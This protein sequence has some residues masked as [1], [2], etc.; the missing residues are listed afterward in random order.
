MRQA[1]SIDRDN[2]PVASFQPYRRGLA[3]AFAMAGAISFWVPDVII[4]AEA[5]PSLDAKHGWAIT[6]LAPAIFLFAYIVARRF[7]LK[8]RYDRVGLMM[9]LGVWLSGGLFMTIASIL[10]KSEFIGGTGLW[11]LVP[12]VISVIPIATY[13]LAAY[14]GSLFAL[15]AITM[16][17]LL[18][19]GFR[20]SM[21]LRSSADTTS[22]IAG[23]SPVSEH[24]ESRV[25]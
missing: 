6:I 19:L 15:L 22:N 8:S 16:G 7:A 17:G 23:K 1:Q 4:H 10:S 12:I 5:G 11:R 24:K 13:I 25:A 9:L 18:I 20:A 21:V 3:F 2:A 14:D